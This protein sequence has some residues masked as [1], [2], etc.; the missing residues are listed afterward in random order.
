MSKGL[1]VAYCR[2]SSSKQI[3]G[4]SLSLQD[5]RELL[6]ALADEYNKEIC[7]RV[8][9]DKG[10]SAYKGQH[11]E[12]DGDLKKLIDDI[13]E[14]T[15]PEGSIIV[16]RHLD[17]L[18][19]LN[20]ENSMELYT[21]LLQ[22]VDIYTT[23]DKRLYSSKLDNTEK[24]I[25]GALAGFAFATANEE[26]LRKVY[27]NH[28]N[29]IA[30]IERFLNGERHSSG[31]PFDIGSG[32]HP[33]FAKAKS[34]GS[35]N[36]PVKPTEHWQTIKS[37]IKFALEGNGLSRCRDFLEN[38]GLN[39]TRTGVRQLLSNS[40]LYGRYETTI[41]GKDYV[42]DG[43]YDF[44]EHGTICTQEEYW[45]LQ[46]NF[47]IRTHGDGRRKEY[48]LL[49]GGGI[50]HCGCGEFMSI[51]HSK[52]KKKYYT[53]NTRKH[54]L[55]PCYVLDNLVLGNLAARLFSLAFDDSKLNRLKQKL[56]KESAKLEKL[57]NYITGSDEQLYGE[58]GKKKLRG[59]FEIVKQ[60]EADAA[61]EQKILY[62][63]KSRNQDFDEISR[64]LSISREK[65]KK[66]LTA[67]S[68]TKLEFHKKIK[69]RVENIILYPDHLIEIHY[70]DSKKDYYYFPKCKQR[71]KGQWFGV[72]L[73]VV[74]KE[75]KESIHPDDDLSAY[76]YTEQ[77]IHDHAYRGNLDKFVNYIDYHEPKPAK[78]LDLF[79]ENIVSTLMLR[80]SKVLY[81]RKSFENCI[82]PKQWQTYKNADLTRFKLVKDDGFI[83]LMDEKDA[84]IQR[85]SDIQKRMH[86]QEKGSRKNANSIG[87]RS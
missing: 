53:C 36:P 40:A 21:K 70:I 16:M 78:G 25:N 84:L 69:S 7:E 6:K 58:Q 68:A 18:S 32:Q 34:E 60:L 44:P 73:I 4:L 47:S 29:A 74:E 30:Q 2:V 87:M 64:E 15:I 57:R 71:S 42:L 19:R 31:Y 66:V 83:K 86:E 45:T 22:K 35:K 33:V 62:K 55:I 81:A 77:E 9:N 37:L 1:I 5:D 59:Q 49:S 82:T 13:N 65:I 63:L 23:M 50:L 20:Y 39:Y 46:H 85:I 54:S 72:K 11:L 51:H 12:K 8:Y 41:N 28:Q 67:D 24:A 17:R 80:G 27:Y 3:E 48:S 61:S 75:W 38:E 52:N 79:A 14:G 56:K 76:V 43:Y 10:K 26:S